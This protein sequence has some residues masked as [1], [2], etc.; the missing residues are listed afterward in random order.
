MELTINYFIEANL[1]LVLL[2]LIYKGFVQPSKNYK[3]AQPFLIVGILLSIG[4]PLLTLQTMN[5]SSGELNLSQVWAE[6]SVSGAAS[7]GNPMLA[8]VNWMK[9]IYAAGTCSLLVLFILRLVRLLN[10]KSKAT[11]TKTHF[12]LAES[13]AAF[14]FMNWI[15][16]GSNYTT[17]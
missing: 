9:I 4:L 5:I 6:V 1:Y 10:V 11:K 12:E 15:F 13:T 16:I 14:S 7:T 2:F 17:E 8:S 3:I